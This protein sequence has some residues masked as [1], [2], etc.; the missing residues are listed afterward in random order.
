MDEIKNGIYKAKISGHVLK[1]LN[2]G[3][4]V[5]EFTFELVDHGSRIWWTGWLDTVPAAGFEKSSLQMTIETLVESMEWDAFAAHYRI[6]TLNGSDDL[7]GRMVQLVV[8]NQ[9]GSDGKVYPRVKYVNH[10]TRSRGADPLERSNASRIGENLAENV[11]W[12]AEAV[13]SPEGQTTAKDPHE[14]HPPPEEPQG[15]D[16]D[17]L[18]F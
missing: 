6:D 18:P 3:D 13:A 12:A 4:H 5:L 7:V 10:P 17:G 15:M 14:G 9:K 11:R 8:E 1:E 2:N 16:G